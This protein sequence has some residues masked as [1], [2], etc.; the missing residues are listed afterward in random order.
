[1]ERETLLK[2]FW[3]YGRALT[4]GNLAEVAR[5]YEVPAFVLGDQGAIPVKASQEVEA[6][7]GGAAEAYR[8]RGLVSAQPQLLSSE[9]ISER[10]CV[11]VIRWSYLDEDGRPGDHSEYHYVLRSDDEGRPKIRVVVGAA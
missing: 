10:L 7:F 4:E 9:A 5:C 3:A 11:A 2:F 8:A 6:A 1:M